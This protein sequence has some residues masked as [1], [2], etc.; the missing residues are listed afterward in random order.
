MVEET[1]EYREE[2]NVKRNDFM[3]LLIQLKKK[4]VVD[5]EQEAVDQKGGTPSGDPEAAEGMH[6]HLWSRL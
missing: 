1:V 4:G 2:Y 3:Q 5:S 6:L